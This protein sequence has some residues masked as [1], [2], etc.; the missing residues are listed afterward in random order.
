MLAHSVE[1]AHTAAPSVGSLQQV[2]PAPRQSAGDP[3]GVGQAAA[4]RHAPTVPSAQHVVPAGQSTGA[5]QSS[6]HSV[7]G[8]HTGPPACAQHVEP[9]GQPRPPAHG[10][11][12]QRPGSLH[13][14]PVSRRQQTWPPGQSATLAQGIGVQ[15]SGGRQSPPQHVSSDGQSYSASHRMPHASADKQSIGSAPQQHTVLG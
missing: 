12:T 3:H 4:A 8:R 2:W 6:G 14:A 5:V 10:V 7:A 1:G 13:A 9:S 11:S 15:V